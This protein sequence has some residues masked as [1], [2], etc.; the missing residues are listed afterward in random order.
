MTF[1]EEQLN[2]EAE[3]QVP[4]TPR[5]LHKEI[6][7]V[8]SEVERAIE[9]SESAVDNAVA[10]FLR[11]A[12]H[13]AE[14]AKHAHGEVAEGVVMEIETEIQAIVMDFQFQDLLKQRLA[15]SIKT[16]MALEV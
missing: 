14:L 5:S 10:G 3:G 6:L 16:L 13:A 12:A 15:K 1:G 9:D 7:Q 8:V 2:G 4:A 11:V